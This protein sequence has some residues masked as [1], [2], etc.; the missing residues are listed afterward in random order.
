MNVSSKARIYELEELIRKRIS[1]DP[2]FVE[3]EIEIIADQ[4]IQALKTKESDVVKAVER[5]I[6]AQHLNDLFVT[7]LRQ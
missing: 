6:I 2:K 1:V 5:L 3:R 7:T 4:G